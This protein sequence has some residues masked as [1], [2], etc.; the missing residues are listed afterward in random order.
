MNSISART[1][2]T[3]YKTLHF[4]TSVLMDEPEFG[5]LGMEDARRILLAE[6]SWLRRIAGRPYRDMIHPDEVGTERALADRICKE[7]LTWFGHMV[8]MDDKRLP[9]KALYRHV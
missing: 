3:L 9:V 4:V 2:I 8:R 7:R 1:K 6:I 5:S